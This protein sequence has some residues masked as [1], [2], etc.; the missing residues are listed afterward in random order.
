[1][2]TDETEWTWWWGEG[3][4]PE[5]YHPANS[6][7]D[8]IAL[9][10]EGAECSGI[11]QVTICEG[12]PWDLSDSFF[13]VGRVLEDWHEHNQ[14]AQDED[15]ELRMSPT[16]DQSQELENALNA[17]FAE[18]RARHKLG[19]SWALDTRNEE[20]IDLPQPVDAE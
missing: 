8:A 12:K 17:T 9:A 4:G 20:V 6:R 14:E 3:R 13:D 15:G 7:E 11:Y 1:M 19:R 10:A 2:A 5:R 16:A 18:W